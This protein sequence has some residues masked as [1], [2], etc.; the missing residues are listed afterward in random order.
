[1]TLYAQP[2][3]SA[4]HSTTSFGL[5]HLLASCNIAYNTPNMAANK[6]TSTKEIMIVVHPL[7][8]SFLYTPPR[9]N[10]HDETVKNSSWCVSPSTRVTRVSSPQHRPRRTTLELVEST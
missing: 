10:L 4:G 2:P 5:G 6:N 7:S 9:W 3:S 8:L 1:M